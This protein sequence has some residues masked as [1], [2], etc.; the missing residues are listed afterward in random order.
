MI[1]SLEYLFKYNIILKS[2][3]YMTPV[4]PG[5]LGRGVGNRT[6]NILT[7]KCK[8]HVTVSELNPNVINWAQIRAPNVTT[9][10]L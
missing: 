7:V 1:L 4:F 6:P 2:V 3:K 8:S 10:D 9:C 5:G